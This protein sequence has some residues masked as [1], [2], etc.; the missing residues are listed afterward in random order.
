MN[1]SRR[2]FLRAARGL[3]ASG[4]A[5]AP[6]ALR[7]AGLG[8]MAAQSARAAD[9]GGPYRAL[10]CLYMAGGNDSHNWFVPTDNGGYADYAA[11]RAE[12][13][14]ARGRL[15]PLTV[16]NQATGRSFG[17]ADALAPLRNW[18][19]SGK[20]AVV[21]NVG[22]LERPIT[23][24][25]Y[26]AG[27]YLPS[28]LF[29]HNDQ[30]STWQSLSPEG[31]LSGWG[32][33]M[34]D[35]LM[36]ANRHPVFTSVSA[37]GNAVFLSGSSVSQYQVSATGPVA[38]NAVASPW[39]QGSNTAVGALRRVLQ[40]GGAEPFQSE[41]AR[42]MQRSMDTSATLQAA[43]AGVPAPPWPTAPITLPAGGTLALDQ[44]PLARQLRVVA[45]MIQAAPA[46]GMQR[47][48]FMVSMGGFDTHANQ[49]RDQPLL[50]SRVAHSVDWFLN[51]L[52]TAGM[53]DQITLFSASDFGRA[54]AS[55][56]SGC[57]HGW[58]GHHFVA[59][60]AVKGRNIYG[61][62]PS[63]ALGSADDVGLGRL[64]PST[65]VTEYAAVLGRWMGL[66]A[67]ELATVLPGLGNFARSNL[68]FL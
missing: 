4:V 61:R 34:G 21:A 37:S 39:L 31:A 59:G 2:H 16:S 17:M 14:W 55:N 32:G 40:R 5:N 29:S 52:N 46:L 13:A 41:Y 25:D 15:L 63:T 38:V 27:R 1:T 50:M 48:V 9:G 7:L 12:L 57:D 66:S 65:S 49:M 22:P 42:V 47:Q 19:E 56:G 24:A 60:G 58:G 64:L 68:D 67:G 36:A 54:L 8:A 18:Y 23:A 45:Q 11:A 62:F 20:L 30:A 3:A 28:K 10:V 6:L 33:R 26:A 43:L 53:L 44:E 35:V 51:A